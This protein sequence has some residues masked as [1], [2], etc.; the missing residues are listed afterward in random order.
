MVVSGLA[1]GVDTEA[2]LAAL[3]AGGLT[4]AVLG[5]GL[6][7]VY[8]SENRG[9]AERIERTGGAVLSEVPL[10]GPPLAANFP[11]RN[12]ILSGLSWVVVV[13][14]AKLRSGA[15]ITA[16]LAGE[17]GREV[18][19]VPG[20]IDSP[21]SEGPLRLL[22]EGARP[23]AEAADIVGALPRW[24][25]AA[26]GLSLECLEGRQG[27]VTGGGLDEPGKSHYKEGLAENRAGR[28]DVVTYKERLGT[29]SREILELIGHEEMHFETLA[30]RSGLS[31]P[32]LLRTLAE[33]EIDGQIEVLPGQR[34]A[35]R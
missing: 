20:P 5:S 12:R 11:R 4:W 25:G 13:V 33:L 2:H 1:R 28:M 19:A 14:E 35:R 8:P 6:D 10:D 30:S 22:R 16:R 21:L 17:Q 27:A 31:V 9:L 15:L 23:V 32:T 7:R 18:G 34:Y 24:L 3:E 29:A 26:S